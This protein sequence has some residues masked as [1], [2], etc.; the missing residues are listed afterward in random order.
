MEQ[1]FLYAGDQSSKI[2]YTEAKHPKR[3][4]ATEIRTIKLPKKG[5]NAPYAK[6]YSTDTA[7]EPC[8]RSGPSTE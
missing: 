2:R 3:S 7:D 6:D 8:P 4:V 5:F 1:S